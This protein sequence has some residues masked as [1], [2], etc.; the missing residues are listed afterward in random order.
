[1]KV[2]YNPYEIQRKIRRVNS[3]AYK[4]EGHDGVDKDVFSTGSLQIC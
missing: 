4:K 3:R 2:T 1:M